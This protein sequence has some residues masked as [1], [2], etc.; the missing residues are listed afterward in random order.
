M[1]AKTEISLLREELQKKLESLKTAF[2]E[3]DLLYHGAFP[4]AI[5]EAS[6]LL[7]CNQDST[8]SEEF[9]RNLTLVTSLLDGLR[10]RIL[11]IAA[12]V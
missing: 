5:H 11:E 7:E 3:L 1:M 10:D 8:P 6:A 9:S 12:K 2:E 4:T